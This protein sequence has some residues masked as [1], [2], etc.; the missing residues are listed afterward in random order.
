[1][2]LDIEFIQEENCITNLQTCIIN[3]EIPFETWH[4]GEKGAPTCY[5]QATT[6]LTQWF[7]FDPFSY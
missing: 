2:Y 1:M 3:F 7:M 6:Y 5:L 4:I